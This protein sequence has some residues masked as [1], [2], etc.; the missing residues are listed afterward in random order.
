MFIHV[1][2]FLPE[3]FKLAASAQ[4]T[5]CVSVAEWMKLRK[6]KS[7][8]TSEVKQNGTFVKPKQRLLISQGLDSVS[9]ASGLLDSA[10]VL[11]EESGKTLHLF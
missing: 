11:C 9:S 7:H 3:N 8:T 2:S 4:S 6:L 1:A 10:L 5:V